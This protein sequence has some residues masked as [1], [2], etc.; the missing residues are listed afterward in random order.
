[1]VESLTCAAHG[2]AYSGLCCLQLVCPHC[3]HCGKPTNSPAELRSLLHSVLIDSF[4]TRRLLTERIDDT[5][6]RWHA[7]V[8]KTD[9]EAIHQT[10]L[11]DLSQHDQRM[12]DFKHTYETED[13]LLFLL[14][15][16]VLDHPIP[17]P[18]SF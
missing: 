8:G 13:D 3:Q 10:A 11:Q 2:Q 17:S 1:M 9:A 6:Q 12:R 18:S 7:N 5:F 4:T 15:F 16:S 14:R